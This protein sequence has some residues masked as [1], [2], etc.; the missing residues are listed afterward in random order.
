[1]KLPKVIA[2]DVIRS[3]HQY[4]SHG[5]VYLID[6][7][8]E[9]VNKMIDWNC[10]TI[11]FEG[12][13]LDRGLRGIA[14]Y[15]N[16]IYIA[17]SDEVFVFDTSFKVIKSY[18]NQYLSH[19]H[20]INVQDDKLYLTSTGFD[21]ILEFDLEREK[22]IRGIALRRFQS[23]QNR[24][25]FDSVLESV[26][27]G[28]FEPESYVGPIKGDTSHI[29]NVVPLKDKILVSGVKLSSLYEID[30]IKYTKIS[31]LP[32][33]THNATLYKDGILYHSTARDLV[34]YQ[35]L[36]GQILQEYQ[37]PRYDETKLLNTDL[38]KDHARQSFGRGL[39]TTEDGLIIVGSSP[40]TVSVYDFESG[41]QIKSINLT[42]DIRNAI[43]GLEVY[44]F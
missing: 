39:C 7:E 5:G 24:L 9:K 18:R 11:N 40:S 38:P 31:S 41:N 17:A 27:K 15:K 20:E 14:F 2:T 12:R 16:Q 36:E 21:S 32:F 43:H 23:S 22:F 25:I 26:V 13:G 44:P 1:M 29:N 30:Q 10:S 37:L 42:M 33:W 4:Q 8:L 19:C 3:A 34:C 28:E 35:T 6:L